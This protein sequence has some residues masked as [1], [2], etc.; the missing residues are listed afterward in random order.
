MKNTN[1]G[2]FSNIKRFKIING[3]VLRLLTENWI[4]LYDANVK[5]ERRTV[6]GTLQTLYVFTA[7]FTACPD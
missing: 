1:R 7:V 5:L 3:F 4:R 2:V 6:Y